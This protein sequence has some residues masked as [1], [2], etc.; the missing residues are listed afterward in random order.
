MFFPTTGRFEPATRDWLLPVHGWVYTPERSTRMR[1][2]TL[3][4]FRR[5]LRYKTREALTPL[6]QER[7]RAFFV[8]GHRGQHVS[9]RFGDEEF[10]LDRSGANGH[11]RGLIRLHEDRVARLAAEGAAPTGWLDFQGV[12]E[13]AIEAAAGRV[14]LL[15]PAGV[16]VVSDIDDTI[17]HTHVRH[18]GELLANTFLR[19]FQAIPA[20]AEMYREW[21]DLGMAF[22]YVSSSPWQLFDPL[23]DFFRREGFPDGSFHLRLLRLGDSRPFKIFVGRPVYKA[24][25]IEAILRTYPERKFVFVGDSGERDP[26]IYGAVARKHPQQVLRILI[27][28]VTGHPSNSERYRKAFRWLPRN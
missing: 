8:G 21:S 27:R 5:Y 18:R 23:S 3:A 26:E 14:Q 28:D 4:L 1:R 2:A 13:G 16:S 15:P 10:V 19:D 24:A 7:T 11:V 22:H 20:A 12:S 17:K 6:F 9:V 25:A